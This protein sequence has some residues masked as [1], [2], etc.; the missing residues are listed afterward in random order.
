M[1]S[2]E[3]NYFGLVVSFGGIAWEAPVVLLCGGLCGGPSSLFCVSVWD[4]L[5]MADSAWDALV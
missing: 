5:Y 3:E 2:L 1:R 4:A